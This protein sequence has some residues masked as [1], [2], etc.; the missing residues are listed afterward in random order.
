MSRPDELKEVLNMTVNTIG[1]DLL[2]ALLQEI[3]LLPD[4]WQKMSKRKQDDVLDRLRS[5]VDANIKMAVHLI[6]SE[7]RTVVAGTL[8]QITIK[9]GVKAV[10]KFNQNAENLHELYESNANP[11]LVV[12]A[13]H[14]EHTGG[15]DEVVGESDQRAMNMGHEYNQRDTGTGL[16]ALN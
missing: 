11:V 9:D 3:K 6:A 4:V 8:D 12:V 5:R 15:M 14:T 1:T 10:V 16:A 13:N 7:G 2:Q